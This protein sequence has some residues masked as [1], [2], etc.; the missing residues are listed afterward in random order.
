M[1]G[2]KPSFQVKSELSKIWNGRLIEAETYIGGHVESLESGVFRE[3]IPVKFNMDP[4]TLQRLIDEVFY[5][6]RHH[7]LHPHHHPHP[8]RHPP[9]PSS[10]SS[11]S[12]TRH[13]EVRH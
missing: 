3:D 5:R 1:T 4:D 12:G 7:H 10:S 8:R 6:H 13:S 11:Q 2:L 9:S